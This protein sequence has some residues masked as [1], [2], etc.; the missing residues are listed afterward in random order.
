MAILN[1]LLGIITLRQKKGTSENGYISPLCFTPIEEP[2]RVSILCLRN[3]EV[4][5][6]CLSLI[7]S[8]TTLH[9]YQSLLPIRAP[10]TVESPTKIQIERLSVYPHG[11]VLIVAGWWEES[12]L[13]LSLREAK[14][15]NLNLLLCLQSYGAVVRW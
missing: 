11:F 10:E 6:S 15:P 7:S 12:V 14:I 9:S 3:E 4:F 2:K 5:F 1:I 8:S 13:F